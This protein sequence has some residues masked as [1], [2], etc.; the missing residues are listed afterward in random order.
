MLSLIIAPFSFQISLIM[1]AMR[2]A[3]FSF[4]NASDFV[5]LFN[6]CFDYYLAVPHTMAALSDQLGPVKKEVRLDEW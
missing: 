3:N 4:D 6:L 5:S 1:L 2:L